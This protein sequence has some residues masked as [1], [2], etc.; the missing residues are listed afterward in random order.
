MLPIGG[1]PILWHIMK[2][3][4]SFGHTEFV[5]ALGWLGD[6]IRRFFL[7]YQALT[8]DF[9]VELGRSGHIEFLNSHPEEG[10]RVTCIETGVDT[11]TGTR[12]RQATRHVREGPVMVTYG[13]AV[14]T[15]DIGKLLAY[16]QSHGKLATVTAV[17][18]P[19]RFGELVIREDGLI[20]E[21]AEKPQTS[22]GSINGG[23]MVFEKEA[24]DRY[25]PTDQGVML[26]REPMSALA[27]DGELVAYQ[28]EGFWQPMDTPRERQLL[29]ELWQSERAPW[30]VWA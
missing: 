3:Y 18:P 7:Q 28:H 24:I 30:K 27:K 1:M 5:L 25:I 4:A 14:G 2:I 17:H 19:G 26:E 21:F 10:W 22:A 15:V 12:V 6:E 29:E 23:F 11:L 13:D 8:C 9:T 20:T 16:H